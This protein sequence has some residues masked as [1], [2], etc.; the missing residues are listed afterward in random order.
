M[1]LYD[2]YDLYERVHAAAWERLSCTICTRTCFLV[3]IVYRVSCVV[4]RTATVLAR[5]Y[6]VA[7]APDDVVLFFLVSYH[8]ATFSPIPPLVDP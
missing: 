7:V 4:C 6:L 2:L 1:I 3:L 5:S 8:T